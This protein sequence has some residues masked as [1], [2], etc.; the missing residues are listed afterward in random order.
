M[1][2]Q[3]PQGDLK[4]SAAIPFALAGTGYGLIGILVIIVLVLVIWR[5]I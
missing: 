2:R 3:T 4:M 5:L 1:R